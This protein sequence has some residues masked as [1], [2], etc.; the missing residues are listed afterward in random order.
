[1]RFKLLRGNQV[2]VPDWSLL[3]TSD[4]EMLLGG[5]EEGYNSD[6]YTYESNTFVITEQIQAFK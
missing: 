2:I 5:G 6:T 3:V 4:G 1:M